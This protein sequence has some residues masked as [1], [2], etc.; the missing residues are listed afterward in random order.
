M[1]TLTKEHAAIIG[2]HTGLLA[3]PFS[4]MHE[5]IEK[6]MGRPVF[7]HELANDKTVAEIKQKSKAD[8]L[9]ICRTPEDAVIDEVKSKL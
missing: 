2:A 9:A 4:E 5:Y 1:K 3:G 6:I 8:F 7:T